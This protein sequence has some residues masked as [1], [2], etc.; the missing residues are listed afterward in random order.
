MDGRHRVEQ[1]G[2]D[3]GSG[4]D[5]S[6]GSGVVALGMT[7]SGMHPRLAEGRDGLQ[8]VLALRSDRHH[9]ESRP[10]CLDESIHRDRVRI[11]QQ[12]DSMG[13]L[14]RLCEEGSLEVN[15]GDLVLVDELT[16]SSDLVDDV[17]NGGGHR[18]GEEGRRTLAA[19]VGHGSHG[20]VMV[21][22]GEV[23]TGAAMAVGV[24]VAR[25]DPLVDELSLRID[26]LPDLGDAS[27]L[28]GDRCR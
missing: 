23:G 1:V 11:A 27:G 6:A 20:G 17:V 26:T 14:A 2:D 24:D 7:D 21:G 10:S 25:Q 13:T 12:L 18:G 22:I 19:V 3:I 8:T 4:I 16:E 9:P 15:A 28:D 5:G